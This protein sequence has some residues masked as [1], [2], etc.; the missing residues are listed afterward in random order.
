MIK[1][2]GAQ[3][4]HILTMLGKISCTFGF[5]SWRLDCDM[6]GAIINC[7]RKG[8]HSGRN[9]RRSDHRRYPRARYFGQ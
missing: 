3:L 7:R 1:Y 8:C 4:T 6:A 9:L 2:S 5:H